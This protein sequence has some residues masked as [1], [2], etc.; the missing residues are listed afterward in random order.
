M[1]EVIIKTANENDVEVISKHEHHLSK[2]VLRDKISRNEI[3]AV[4][5]NGIFIGWLRY[6][7][8]MDLVPFMYML[9][10][11]PEYRGMGLGKKLV[12]HWEKNMRGQG[13]KM[14]MTSTQQNEHA[15][16]FYN[17]LGYVAVG[18]FIQTHEA[19]TD[20]SYEIILSKVL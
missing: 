18:G 5:D 4:F 11:L 20:E 16:H 9:E 14:V 2:A 10:L 8:F 12:L 7:M 17:A 6:G 1:S 3:L 13:Y 15:Q 19:L